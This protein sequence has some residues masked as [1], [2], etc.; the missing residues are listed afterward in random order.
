MRA[1]AWC[2]TRKEI[3]SLFL[4]AGC[5]IVTH[6]Q[7]SAAHSTGERQKKQCLSWMLSDFLNLNKHELYIYRNSNVMVRWME[8]FAYNG[9]QQWKFECSKHFF[10]LYHKTLHCN[11]F[12]QMLRSSENKKK[13]SA[14]EWTQ[15]VSS[16]TQ[17]WNDSKVANLASIHTQCYKTWKSWKQN[18]LQREYLEWS[19]SIPLIWNDIIII[20]IKRSPMWWSWALSPGD[21][22]ELKTEGCSTVWGKQKLLESSQF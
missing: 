7:T 16:T 12:S 9:L 20:V 17:R 21:L 1:F 18:T 4:T 8:C 3:S 10:I 13:G 11:A 14:A 15:A 2:K 6:Q 5:Q 19:L 22:Y